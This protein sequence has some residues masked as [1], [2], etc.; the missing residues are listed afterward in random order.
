MN[1]VLMAAFAA[2]FVF[3]GIFELVGRALQSPFAGYVLTLLTTGL[4][5][6]ALTLVA[7]VFIAILYRR[8][9]SGT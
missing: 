8:L 1:T 5:S 7:T 2:Q 9:S 4:V 6:T 3:G